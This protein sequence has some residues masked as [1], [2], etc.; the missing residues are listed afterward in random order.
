MNSNRFPLDIASFKK[1]LIFRMVV[2]L[3]FNLCILLWSLFH[4][5][6]T[7]RSNYFLVFLGILLIIYFWLYKKYKS[8]LYILE[9]TYITIDS[10]ELNFYTIQNICSTLEISSITEIKKDTYK[11]YPTII[12]NTKEGD[13]SLVNYTNLNEIQS[14]LESFT[15]LKTEE[16]KLAKNK[17]ITQGILFFIP[18]LL[19]VIIITLDS[20]NK[21]QS[22][23]TI[24]KFYLIFILNLI[25]FLNHFSESRMKGGIPVPTVRKLIIIL[26]GLLF[27]LGYIE[28]I[29]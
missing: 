27:Y 15:G 8:Q 12:L 4:I 3:G 24:G 19:G 5:E 6:A 9:N 7:N 16:I 25:F 21:T 17:F 29:Q 10:Q 11:G 20:M 18:S 28:F 14:L 13:L 26:S 23:L 1:R 22:Q 2:V